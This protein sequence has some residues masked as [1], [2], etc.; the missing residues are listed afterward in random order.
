M[1]SDGSLITAGLIVEDSVCG[2]VGISDEFDLAVFAACPRPFIVKVID[3][4]SM[5]S[6]D[7]VRGPANEHFSNI[8]MGLKV[9]NNI[10]IGTFLG[11]RIAFRSL[12]QHD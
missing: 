5:E 6:R 1:A 12:Q 8:T 3:P 7:I 10:W 4:Q 11:D 2:N 9:G